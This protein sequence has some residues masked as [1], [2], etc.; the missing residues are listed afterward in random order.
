MIPYLILD[1]ET[2]ILNEGDPFDP[3]NSLCYVGLRDPSGTYLYDIQYGLDPYASKLEE[4]KRKI[5]QAEFL[6]GFNLK[7]D[8][9]WIRRYLN[10]PRDSGLFAM[11]STWD[12]QLVEYLLSRQRLRMPSLDYVSASYSL[13][14]KLDCVRTDYWENGIDTKL[15]PRQLLEEYLTQDL[16]LTEQIFLKQQQKVEAKS[17]AFKKLVWLHN[18]DTKVLQEME[19][20]GMQVNL[21]LNEVKRKEVVQQMEETDKQLRQLSGVP[22]NIPLNLSSTHQLSAIIYGGYINYPGKRN[23]ER[24][25][26]NGEVKVTEVN[27]VLHHRCSG[28]ATPVP[29]SETELTKGMSDLD[30]NEKQLEAIESNKAIPFR[31]Y[32]VDEAHLRR[33]KIRTKKGREF[34][35]LLLKRAY[36]DQQLTTYLNK[37][38]EMFSEHHWE[39][40]LIHGQFNQCVARTGRLSSS[41]PNLQ[42]LDSEL[43]YLF[44]SRYAD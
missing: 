44:T 32:S 26:K 33:A 18:E 2:T 35:D 25:L 43:H 3:R 17:E 4:I 15:V 29:K 36:L 28:F 5:E 41:K 9:H 39:N 12:C 7:F 37:I 30:L 6:V 13:P 42:N 20:N 10:D 21:D 27:C 34:V 40:N 38:P 22:E 19:F 11:V 14:S 16:Y 8:L 31:K 24:L 1:V 23:K